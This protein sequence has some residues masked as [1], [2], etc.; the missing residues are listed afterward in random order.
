MDQSL[1]KFGEFVI[2]NLLDQGIDK[3]KRLSNGEIEA[4]SLQGLQQDSQ[5]FNAKDMEVVQRLIVEIMTS[6]THD[7]L[8]AL[9]ER[10]ELKE[11]IQITV[12]NNSITELSDGIQGELFSDNGWIKRYSSYGDLYKEK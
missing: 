2:K 5:S 7:F 8:Y 1:D 10:A 9:Q 3:F 12:D 4:P 11:D 6:T